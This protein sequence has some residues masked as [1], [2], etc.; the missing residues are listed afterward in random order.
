MANYFGQETEGKA[1]PEH[2]LESNLTRWLAQNRLKKLIPYFEEEEVVLDEIKA[3]N[4]EI[5]EL[6]FAVD[7]SSSFCQYF[8]YHGKSI[9]VDN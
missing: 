7:F 3:Y 2:N 5:I 8:D 6:R 9:K 1:D 4:D